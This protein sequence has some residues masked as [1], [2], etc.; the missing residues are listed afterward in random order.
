MAAFDRHPVGAVVK[1]LLDQ[2]RRL[3]RLLVQSGRERRE[4]VEANANLRVELA[5]AD[6]LLALAMDQMTQRNAG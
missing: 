5:A 6:A 2:N 3:S 1:P 4:L